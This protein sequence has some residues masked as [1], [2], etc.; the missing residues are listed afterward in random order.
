MT[1]TMPTSITVDGP[2]S[3]LCSSTLDGGSPWYRERAGAETRTGGLAFTTIADS[4]H[5]LEMI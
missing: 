3:I 1:I 2:R 4:F 5:N